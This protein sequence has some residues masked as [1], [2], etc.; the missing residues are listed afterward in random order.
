MVSDNS[1]GPSISGKIPEAFEASF[2]VT[3][4]SVTDPRGT[5]YLEVGSLLHGYVKHTYHAD[6]N[7]S[8]SN[9]VVF[10]RLFEF[11]P[12]YVVHASVRWDLIYKLFD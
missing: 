2:V 3:A 12:F 10:A 6:G 11:F 8:G 5:A 1:S 7:H 9:L 4:Q